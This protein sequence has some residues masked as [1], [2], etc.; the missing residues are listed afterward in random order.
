VDR[1]MDKGKR[2]M[3]RRDRKVDEGLEIE[4][5]EMYRVAEEADDVGGKEIRM[6][7]QVVDRA[8]KKMGR[9]DSEEDRLDIGRTVIDRT[10]DIVDRE[11]EMDRK[12]GTKE[13]SVDTDTDIVNMDRKEESVDIE[14]DDEVDRMGGTEEVDLTDRRGKNLVVEHEG[15]RATAPRERSRQGVQVKLNN[16]NLRLFISFSP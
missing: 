4:T 14:V 8:D 10:V 7:R 15:G 2:M 5:M 1:T 11:M 13:G 6:G 12:D 3:D 9:V 16:S